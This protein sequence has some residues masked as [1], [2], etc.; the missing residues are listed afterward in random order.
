MVGGRKPPSHIKWSSTWD[1]ISLRALQSD[2]FVYYLLDTQNDRMY[3]RRQ[4]KLIIVIIWTIF[5][6][7]VIRIIIINASIKS[8]EYLVL[9]IARLI[10]LHLEVFNFVPQERVLY[11][12]ALAG[13]Q[14]GKQGNLFFLSFRQNGILRA[15]V[16]FSNTLFHYFI[17]AIAFI[18]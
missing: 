9:T 11:Y 12:F 5:S 18:I 2:G 13:R 1:A 14:S 3:S 15:C 16:N 7:I 17:N 10:N 8:N 4:M 6:N